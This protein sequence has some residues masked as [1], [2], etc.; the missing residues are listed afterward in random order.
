MYVNAVSNTPT[1]SFTADYSFAST[2]TCYI[3]NPNFVGQELIGRFGAFHAYSRALSSTE[4]TN[5]YNALKGR[6]GL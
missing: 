1:N 5:N 4:V 3:G 2:D 6:Y